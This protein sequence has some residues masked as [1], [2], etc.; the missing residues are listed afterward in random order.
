MTPWFF[1]ATRDDAH[2]YV[3]VE[4]QLGDEENLVVTAVQ[5]YKAKWN[6]RYLPLRQET[7]IQYNE[8]GHS[9]TKTGKSG[10]KG[11]T[12]ENEAPD[13]KDNNKTDGANMDTREGGSGN[14]EE[15]MDKK[16]EAADVKGQTSKKARNPWKPAMGKRVPN[17]GGGDCLWHGLARIMSTPAKPRSHRQVR[18]WV[19][20][21]MQDNFAEYDSLWQGA[22]SHDHK[23]NPNSIAT[24]QIYLDKLAQVGIYSG[25]L[26]ILAFAKL[27]DKRVWVLHEDGR[28]F[29]FNEAGKG[30]AHGFYFHSKGHYEV[31]DDIDELEW[32]REKKRLE[33][34]GGQGAARP[35]LRGG[36][37][38][39]SEFA[40]HDGTARST[41]PV[42]RGAR[43]LSQ[44]ASQDG[45]PA[46]AQGGKRKA[47][48]LTDF[49]STT[50][51]ATKKRA[52]TSK[53]AS[54]R[55]QPAAKSQAVETRGR[56]H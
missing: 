38:S 31:Y 13:K 20:A 37:R 17:A 27:A 36:A 42:P 12:A 28:V 50:S 45:N 14:T 3:Q 1:Q 56:H 51:R 48:A 4:I 30:D 34:E 24:F 39:L 10:S 46:A 2:Q 52:A 6:N 25:A 44:F 47:R 41:C 55:R 11:G 35:V 32:I 53:A 18:L 22:G 40:S 33:K 16:R 19:Q 15:G 23:G 5:E 49:A 43:S 29:E 26:E 8:G 54:A 21:Y 7:R 9:G